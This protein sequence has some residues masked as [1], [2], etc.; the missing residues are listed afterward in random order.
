[1]QRGVANVSLTFHVV[2]YILYTI[3]ITIMELW[4][5]H[6]VFVES[7][8]QF[9]DAKLLDDLGGIPI[10]NKMNRLE[11]IINELVAGTHMTV[12]G[13]L[14]RKIAKP[15]QRQPSVCVAVCVSTSRPMYF[16]YHEIL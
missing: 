11:V 8:R 4:N 2:T 3:F 13:N 6:L 9:V 12:K 16:C 15:R 14:L 7:D 10:R 5:R 1:M